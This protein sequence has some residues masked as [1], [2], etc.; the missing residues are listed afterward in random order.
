VHAVS[1]DV[2][3]PDSA[4]LSPRLG[5]SPGLVNDCVCALVRASLA[6]S[7]KRSLIPLQGSNTVVARQAKEKKSHLGRWKGLDEDA[8][9]DQ[10]PLCSCH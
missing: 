6:G 1:L 4:L 9:D 10:V 8:S 3:W 7:P 2:V 5:C